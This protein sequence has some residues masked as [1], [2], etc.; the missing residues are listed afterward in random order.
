MPRTAHG[1]PRAYMRQALRNLRLVRRTMRHTRSPEELETSSARDLVSSGPRQPELAA[2]ARRL[3]PYMH[4]AQPGEAP[5]R[6]PADVHSL[7]EV[8]RLQADPHAL[9]GA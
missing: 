6:A 9:V 8:H 3:G 7:V 2:S 1:A 5:C 4:S